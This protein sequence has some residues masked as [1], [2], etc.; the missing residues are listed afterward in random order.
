MLEQ[1]ASKISSK[2]G[3]SGFTPSGEYMP[4]VATNLPKLYNNI[5]R[6]LN[7]IDTTTQKM[8]DS[9]AISA[10]SIYKRCG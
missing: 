2:Y 9:R 5:P 3:V 7:Q 1:H 10:Q 8:D 6:Y 4:T